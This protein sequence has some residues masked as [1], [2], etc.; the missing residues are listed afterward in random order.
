MTCRPSQAQPVGNA[1]PAA[2]TSAGLFFGGDAVAAPEKSAGAF[3]PIV[4]D[5]EPETVSD[6]DITLP[7]VG[8]LPGDLRLKEYVEARQGAA[9][10]RMAFDDAADGAWQDPMVGGCGHV[11]APR[12][13]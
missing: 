8:E 5:R 10:G 13:R 4:A 2:Q 3:D 6:V 9:I 12:S 11:S 7:E 1:R